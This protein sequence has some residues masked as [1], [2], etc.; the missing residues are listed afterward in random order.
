MSIKD[1]FNNYKSN[2]FK[3][4]ETEL[5]SSKLVE[6]NEFVQNKFIEKFEY[7]PPIDFSDASN[8][9]KFGSA[10]LYYE[11]AFKRIYQQFPYDGTLAEQQEFHNNSTFLDKYV[12]ENVYPRTTGHIKFSPEGWGTQTADASGYGL[13]NTTQYISVLGGPHTASGGME[14]KELT[15]TFDNSMIYD[16]TKRR[17]GSFE[18]TPSSGSTIEFW[19][20]KAGYLGPTKTDREVILD[21]WNGE[22]A[23]SDSYG[24][25]TLELTGTA[26]P[27]RLTMMSGAT[28]FNDINICPSTLLSS[29]IIDDK[30]HHYA[31]SIKNIGSDASIDL[32]RDGTYLSTTTNSNQI[33]SIENVAGGVNAYIGALQTAVK[34]TST[35][36]GWGKLSASLDEFRYW[37]KKR[38]TNEIGEFWFTNLG[39]GTN[40]REYNT[41][42]GVYFKF[43]EGITTSSSIDQTMLD[44][45][46]RISNGIMSG[47][48]ASARS[49]E[50][51]LETLTNVEEYKDPIIYS[52]HPLVASTMA[53]YKT[54]GSVMDYENTSLLY[55]LF[56]SWMAEEDYENGMHLRNLTQIMAS[57][58]DTL[59]AQIN[60]VTEF[61]AKRYFSGSMKPNTFSREI[62]RGQ[63]F[64]IPELFIEADILEEI[65][66]KDNNETYDRDIQEV[67][68]LIYQNIYNN[69]NYIYKS[70]GTEKSFR[71]LFRCFGVDSELLRLNLYADDSTY[72]YRDNYEF[73]SIAK[74]VL[75]LNIEDHLEATV[76][77]SGSNGVTFLSSSEGDSEKHTAFTMEC[78]AI[79]P[80]KFK[81]Y[82]TGYFPTTF[83][84]ISIAGFHRAITS[85]PSDLSWHGTDTSLR[86]YAIKDEATSRH[87][88]FK[89]SGSVGG[90]VISLTSPM[91]TDVY[92]NNKWILAARVK[93][94]DYP[95]AGNITGSATGGGYIVEFYGV[96]SVANDVKN[97]FSVSDT[98]TN[99]IGKALLGH[100]KRVYAGAHKT[101]FTSTTLEKSDVKISQLRF[102]QSHLNDE[103]IKEHS[104]DPTNYGLIHPY[105]SDSIFQVSG[106]DTVYVP[107]IETLALHWDFMTVSTSDVGGNFVVSDVS[108]G[109]AEDA[110]K[111]SV[112]RRIT[113][114]KHNGY[115]AG[116]TA[117]SVNAVDKEFIYAAKKR[118][119][120]EVYSSDGVTIKTESTENFFEDDTTADHYYMFEKSPY[121]AVSQQMIN[122]FGSMRDFNSLIGDPA[123]RYRFEY[124]Q[125]NDLKRLFFEKVENIPDPEAFFEYFKWIDTS[126]SY[127]I[128][129]LIPASSRFAE[130]VKDV[131]ESH[132]LER[133]KYQEKFPLVAQQRSTEGVVKSYSELFYNWQYGHAPLDGSDNK[134]CLWQK[135]RKR[136]SDTNVQTLRD[137]I[138]KTSN[139]KLSRLY[140]TATAQSYE[141]GT[142]AVRR[143]SKPYKI[144]MSLKH[145]IHGGTN[146]YAQKNRD[147]LLEVVHPHGPISAQGSPKNVLVVGVGTGQGLI[148]A[149]VCE[150]E[151]KSEVYKEKYNFDGIDGRYSSNQNH[152]PISDFVSYK[153]FT[154]GIAT[155]PFNI[156][157]QSAPVSTGYQTAVTEKF[158]N[159]A[160]ITNL[161]SD[162]TDRTNVIPM[163][164]PFTERHVGG[165]QHRHVRLNKYDTSLFDADYGGQ[166]RFYKDVPA[167]KSTGRVVVDQSAVSDGDSVSISDGTSTVVFEIDKSNNGVTGG[168]TAVLTGSSITQFG[169]NFSSSIDSS[170]LSF[171]SVSLTVD[172][173]TQYTLFITASV[174]GSTGLSFAGGAM[175][176]T[177]SVLSTGTDPSITAVFEWL[178][179][180]YTRPEAWRL[181]IG[182]NADEDIQ[183]GALGF[184]PPDY[185][186]TAG[187]GI[188]P[189]TAKH[190]A[191]FYREEKAKRPVNVKNIKHRDSGS[192]VGNYNN[193]YEIM[194]L[195]GRRE[196][197]L[198]YRDNPTI[199]DYLPIQYTAS[200]P[201]TT[202]VMSLVGIDPIANGNVFGTHMNN[203]QPDAQMI[204]PAIPGTPAFGSFIVSGSTVDG[205]A[206]S[207]SFSLNRQ[208]SAATPA[209]FSFD[210]SG[211]HY[212]GTAATGS[213]V[214]TRATI[215]PVSAS[216]KFTARGRTIEQVESS[217][218][219]VVTASHVAGTYAH[220]SFNVKRPPY[221]P[222]AQ[223]TFRVSS[224]DFVTSGHTL[225]IVQ[226]SGPNTDDFYIIAGGSHAVA[227]S[228]SIADFY[229][230]LQTDIR[231]YTDYTHTS[232]S[233]TAPDYG[234][235]VVN[236]GTNLS[237]FMSGT[238]SANHWSHQSPWATSFWMHLSSSNVKDGDIFSEYSRGI[239][240][241]SLVRRLYINA[242][243][244][245]N[246][247]VYERYYN[248][249][250]GVDVVTGSWSVQIPSLDMNKWSHYFISQPGSP[251][252]SGS[253]ALPGGGAGF[254][255]ALGFV[256]NGGEALSVTATATNRDQI[257][258]IPTSNNN[259]SFFACDRSLETFSLQ[260]GLDEFGIWNEILDE[261]DNEILYNN[262]LYVAPTTV[263]ASNLKAWWRFGD[264]DYI[265][266][267]TSPYDSDNTG[268]LTTEDLLY[269]QRSNQHATASENS[270]DLFL[271]DSIYETSGSALFTVQRNTT[272]GF[273][274]TNYTGSIT[275]TAGTSFYDPN[276]ITCALITST[277]TTVQDTDTITLNGTVFELDNNSTITGGRTGVA[278][279]GAQ[280]K[281]DFWNVLSQSIKDNTDFD[282][283]VITDGGT[284]ATF[285]VTSST[286]LAARNGDIT[287]ETGT[288]FSSLVATT[289]GTDAS[290]ATDGHF[291]TIDGVRFELDV[292]GD[293]VSSGQDINCGVG[294]PNTTFWN[295][296]SASIK[297]NT[298]F[299]TIA[300]TD[301]GNGTARFSL[302]ASTG[303]DSNNG[304]VSTSGASF[305]SFVQAAGGVD[306]SGST[307]ASWV[308]LTV[309]NSDSY[310]FHVDNDGGNVDGTPARN[311]YVTASTATNADWWNNLSQSMK[312]QGFG[313]S[314]T[315][316]S[317]DATFTVTTMRTGSSGDTSTVSLSSTTNHTAF[318]FVLQ[319]TLTGSS[320][321][322]SHF[323]GGSDIGDGN[324]QDKITIGSETFEMD[325]NG[326]VTGSNHAVASSGSLTA[327]QV[328]NNLTASIKAETN[329]DTINVVGSGDARTLN[330]TSSVVGIGENGKITSGTGGFGTLVATAGGTN[331]S[332]SQYGDT[333]V[334]GNHGS[335]VTITIDDGT[336]GSSLYSNASL[337]NALWWNDLSASIK[338]N[339]NYD[340]IVI[341][342][343]GTSASFQLTS[344]VA[345]VAGNDTHSETGATF[346]NLINSTGGSAAGDASDGSA[347]TID[348]EVFVLDSDGTFSG[349][350]VIASSASLSDNQV[351][352]ALTQSIKDNTVFDTITMSPASGGNRTLSLTSSVTGSDKNGEITTATTH[353]AV[354]ANSAGGTNETGAT[355][356]HTITIGGK[357][358]ELDN[359][360]SV[361]GTN[362]AV[363]CSDSLSNA[364]FWSN[365]SASIKAQTV[366]DTIVIYTGGGLANFHLTSST[367]GSALNVPI[368]KTGDSF[369]L[370]YGM[371]SGSDEIPAVY[372][373][374][375][376]VLAVPTPTLRNGD[377]NKTIISSRFA[378][379]GGVEIES[380]AYL[381]IYAR[382]LS[383]HNALPFRN[384][385]V[386][387]DSGEANQMRIDD[388]LGKRR[389]LNTL[390]ALH[391]GQFGID[392]EY[393]TIVEATYS[394]SGSFNKQHRNRSKRMEYSGSSIITGSLFD[395]AFIST[396]IP[397]SEFQYAWINN[398][399]SGSNWESSQRIL[400]YQDSDGLYSSSAGIV[401]AIRFP[402]SSNI[403]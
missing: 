353:F 136:V 63:G 91:F 246:H 198:Y 364:E 48:L 39:G 303:G 40:T 312:D 61:K 152:E 272:E 33:Q 186:I 130:E 393:G 356:G 139:T 197:N 236:S 307:E 207:G 322:A 120:D 383:V 240:A 176:L 191:S 349:D 30:W 275:V 338:A 85:D 337:A 5:S 382:E 65:R 378:A 140:D 171:D 22:L 341:V 193:N 46:G 57:Y 102:W 175:G 181:L 216:I 83:K 354:V 230:N 316:S 297:T 243:S 86:M 263:S 256:I 75:N 346:S 234:K 328:F 283:I 74:P 301:L 95:F 53:T 295:S 150:D 281:T 385:T 196:N 116:F 384:L 34:G 398:T 302:T 233:E 112:I 42:L 55:H 104:Y 269:E 155:F 135:I 304:V 268:T 101:N 342:D 372:T 397:R 331:V 358:F 224:R 357:V 264:D 352:N 84:E 160:Y 97:E 381:D 401:E 60:G 1:L 255:S 21:I 209:K 161:H 208:I 330:L 24:R 19:M 128:A 278:F 287:T 300:V 267:K 151:D 168:R 380:N 142:D 173:G 400:G 192:T 336:S 321:D 298:E 59:N 392:S 44:Y 271:Q 214:F 294:V 276:N 111:Y 148:S 169:Q 71:N 164:G 306:F 362:V 289:G 370:S 310:K 31:V 159:S 314:Y 213:F 245:N 156:M 363:D 177:P 396:P 375:D 388:H 125:M 49:T 205:I 261:T 351:F 365:L 296:L 215:A 369:T 387:T 138:Y 58:F 50:S 395:N 350:H 285:E 292:A 108:S 219:F 232:Y 202:H 368:T 163:Q 259:Y 64:V 201:H 69:L 36:T 166:P 32:Y 228:S 305:P 153:N 244:G 184:V 93:H 110:A 273:I 76:Y 339:T 37:K 25:I 67:K 251:D 265:T 14:G 247:L 313:V 284:S 222:A 195:Q 8:F 311:F 254:A 68:N 327:D 133:N 390:L 143:L 309:A 389:G 41:D 253:N 78:E 27:I 403:I 394:T 109:S 13:S 144:D 185:G 282:T 315:T 121:A 347:I 99:A 226:D 115:G 260:S 239:G 343:N 2:Q 81:E 132:I 386:R 258:N 113:K 345:G 242:D 170:A 291:I 137:N 223:G 103:E 165:H 126:I 47:Y 7:E 220:G 237:T 87:V 320:Q 333:L 154:K 286:A 199:T 182:D 100:A 51:A 98:V 172:S 178:D 270:T 377:R 318:N 206:A 157:S 361:T 200:L 15:N 340:T 374:N 118:L 203:M 54:T 38:T 266:A 167:V 334:I 211:S 280:V 257:A 399:I 79:F 325:S 106:S 4:T 373:L 77:Q 114:N 187:T 238:F 10:E 376:V 11:F 179:N 117:N 145:N 348:G 218:S 28:G 229:N 360:S 3:P 149:T 262:G 391:S 183:D 158:E 299:D 194:M 23:S 90:T 212:A 73:T 6:S 127:A 366:Y 326:T 355:D 146:Y 52:S 371:V 344:S 359:N 20:K 129:Q 12:F 235:G 35:G 319:P 174:T 250:N 43:N 94:E 290:G 70:K 107:Q 204:S 190:R 119:P 324:E 252:T 277:S 80:Y 134:N 124:K 105:R 72:L 147:Y 367:T 221:Y 379:P 162:T 293:G 45:S 241:A 279:S 402:S 217:G 308:Q 189:D 88:T 17:A 210:V 92:D 332:G 66:G 9:A 141:G 26:G 249:S 96:N 123:E 56:P 274:G 323:V 62:L 231:A 188:Y 248:H 29:D 180:K 131:V 227:L 89:L 16:T 18:W 82:E 335:N 225:R 317:T 329:F 122:F 288:S